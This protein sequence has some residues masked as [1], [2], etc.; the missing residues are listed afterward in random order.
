MKKIILSLIFMLIFPYISIAIDSTVLSCM[1]KIM[2]KGYGSNIA[3]EVCDGFSQIEIS[4]LF[5]VID[6]GYGPS[7]GKQ[8]CTGIT[9]IQL[10]CIKDVLSRGYGLNTASQNCKD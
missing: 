1:K 10:E 7:T 3:R 6:I 9:N 4:C 8:N 5:F 2:D